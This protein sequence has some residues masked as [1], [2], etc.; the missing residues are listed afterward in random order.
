MNLYYHW[1]RTRNPTQVPGKHITI[2]AIPK[3]IYAKY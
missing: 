1:K 2:T 3:D